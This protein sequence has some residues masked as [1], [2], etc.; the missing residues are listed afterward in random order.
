MNEHHEANMRSWDAVSPG[1]QERVEAEG[2]WRRV[3][4][5]PDLALTPR[6]RH[7]LGEVRGKDV[8][9]LGSGDNS[10][11]FALAGL[12]AEVTSVDSSGRQLQTARRRAE[13][14]GLTITF[15]RADVTDLS[16]VPDA[17]FDIVYTGGHVAVWIADLHAFHAE[18]ARTLKPSSLSLINEYHPMRRVWREVNGHL[19]LATR[20]FDRG[21]HEYD[22]SDEVPGAKPDAYPSFEYNWTIADFAS[23]LL[24]SGCELTALE[25]VGEDEEDWETAPLRGLPQSLLVVGRKRQPR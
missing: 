24:G 15:L 14:L 17:S 19:E 5:E 3:H 16:Q 18:A 11:A 8:A 25:E 1:W 9:V 10:V 23:A 2:A 20:Y 21:P 22:R 13:E 12:G 4:Q 7:H 6:E